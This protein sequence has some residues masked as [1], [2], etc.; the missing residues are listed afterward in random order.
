MSE[1]YQSVTTDKTFYF[2]NKLQIFPLTVEK[3]RKLLIEKW[4][5]K[6]KVFQNKF[7]FKCYNCGMK[8]Y[9]LHLKRIEYRGQQ[10]VF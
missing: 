2:V 5:Q 9:S 8:E 1:S 10:G 4:S 3:K 7:P 6:N